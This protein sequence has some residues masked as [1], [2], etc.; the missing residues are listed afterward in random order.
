MTNIFSFEVL[1]SNNYFFNKFN[2]SIQKEPSRGALMKRCFENM[3]QMYKFHVNFFEVAF[4]RGCSLG[5]T[6]GLLLP[7]IIFK[8]KSIGLLY[9]RFFGVEKQ[10]ELYSDSIR[11]KPYFWE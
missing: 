7:K 1:L 11:T 3:Q 4:L 5:V 9:C 2:S 8:Y 6:E 10:Q